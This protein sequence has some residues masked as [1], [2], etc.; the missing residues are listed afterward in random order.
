MSSHLLVQVYTVFTKHEANKL[1][2]QS[3]AV[4]QPNQCQSRALRCLDEISCLSM[5]CYIMIIIKMF[6]N[7]LV[8]TEGKMCQN[9]RKKT[10][11]AK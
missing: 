7:N 3:K 11:K 1:Q 8:Y 6:Q 5:N 9:G 4:L 2:Y 10:M